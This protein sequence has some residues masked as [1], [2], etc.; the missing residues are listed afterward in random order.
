MKLKF[1]SSEVRKQWETS[2]KRPAVL[3]DVVE[4]F[5]SFVYDEFE[6]EPVMTSFLRSAYEDRALGGSGV[7]VRAGAA[8]FRTLDVPKEEV[9]AAVTY[10]NGRWQYDPSRPSLPVAYAK[11]HGNGPHLHLQIHPNTRKR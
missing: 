5:A 11:P 3:V 4:D 7:H 9:A 2:P 10:I 1:K 8:D 6:W